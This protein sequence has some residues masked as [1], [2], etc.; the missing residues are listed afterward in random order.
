MSN[1]CCFD[2]LRITP[3]IIYFL[4]GNV[5]IFWTITTVLQI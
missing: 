1:Q 2:G 3:S 4:T 5:T